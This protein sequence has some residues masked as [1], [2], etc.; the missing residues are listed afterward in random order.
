MPDGWVNF[1][2][3]KFSY[4]TPNIEF[5]FTTS[6]PKVVSTTISCSNG[7]KFVKIKGITPKCPK[8]YSKK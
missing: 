7:K 4:S 6:V 5:A 2:A 1:A 3:K 8:G